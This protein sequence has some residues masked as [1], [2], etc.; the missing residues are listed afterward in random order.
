MNDCAAG[1]VAGCPAG[2]AADCATSCCKA[3]ND[4]LACNGAARGSDP[5]K[6]GNAAGCDPSAEMPAVGAVDMDVLLHVGENMFR[7]SAFE[8]GNAASAASFC[9]LTC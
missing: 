1:C 5:R 3:F 6:A 9:E 7:P 2:P 8:A 4:G